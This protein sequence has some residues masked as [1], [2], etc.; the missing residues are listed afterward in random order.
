MRNS[1][2]HRNLFYHEDYPDSIPNFADRSI[3]PALAR[4]L[5]F[6][7]SRVLPIL[8]D[9][10]PG[11]VRSFSENLV[12]E[13][14]ES[15]RPVVNLWTRMTVSED[16]ELHSYVVGGAGRAVWLV[17]RGSAPVSPLIWERAV[18]GTL[19]LFGGGLVLWRT[20]GIVGEP[21][22]VGFAL[23]ARGSRA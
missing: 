1:H 8:G 2:T 6:E 19:G 12:W 20:M 22:G 13:L 21:A 3:H 4:E 11:L 23:Q 10:T 9:P 15:P 17:F 18:N 14:R 5:A 16:R 7:A